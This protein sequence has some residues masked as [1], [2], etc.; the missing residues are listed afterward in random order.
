VIRFFAPASQVEMLNASYPSY[1][2][3]KYISCGLHPGYTVAVAYDAA[4]GS[5]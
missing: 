4:A 1:R 5:T 3:F 2:N